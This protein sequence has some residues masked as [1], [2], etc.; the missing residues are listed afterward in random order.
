MDYSDNI[1]I[2]IAELI[3]VCGAC[4]G[5]HMLVAP[6]VKL[7]NLIFT[8]L[9]LCLATATHN[10]KCVKITDTYITSVLLD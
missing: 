8:L 2:T 3:N 1:I 4:E 10:F 9:K 7:Q 5:C 6:K